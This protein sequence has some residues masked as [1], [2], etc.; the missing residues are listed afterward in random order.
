MVR[1]LF[2]R[3]SKIRIDRDGHFWHEGARVEH[4]GLARAFARWIALDSETGRYILKNDVDW[5]FVTVDDAPLVVRALDAEMR[6]HLSDDE[7]EPL[8]PKTL[9]IDENDVPYCDV[10]GGTLPARFS[11]AGA[12]ALLE[13][14][15]PAP[16]GGVLIALPG[17]GEIEIPRVPRGQGA[18]VRSPGR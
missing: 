13:R 14:A 11:R 9:R 3:E 18:R 6:L 12:F 7:T 1:P 5:C 2:T 15:R 17:G 4:P 16:S 10:R 8:D